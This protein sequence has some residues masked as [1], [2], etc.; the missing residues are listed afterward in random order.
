MLTE[1]R[2]ELEELFDV[3]KNLVVFE[4]AEDLQDKIRYY[5]P[6]DSERKRIAMSGYSA[7]REHT[8]TNRAEQIIEFVEN[9]R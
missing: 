4:G 5:L 8:Y 2:P 9:V 1:S 6:H 3:G 7:V